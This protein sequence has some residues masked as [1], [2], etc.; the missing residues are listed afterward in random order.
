LAGAA[1]GWSSKR[2]SI[3]ALSSTE[4]EYVG[5]CFAGKETVWLRRIMRD[6]RIGY[7]LEVKP[8]KIF[9]EHQGNQ[10][11]IKIANNSCTSKRLKH[12]DIKFHFTRSVVESGEIIWEYCPT[13]L[14]M[15]DMMTKVLVYSI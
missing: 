1:I 12:I 6:V 3:I 9:A 8:I 13:S 5:L 4:S 15:A 11:S 14:M 10:G 7:D 2:Q